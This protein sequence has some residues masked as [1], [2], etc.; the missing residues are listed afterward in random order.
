M[1]FSTTVYV[2]SGLKAHAHVTIQFSILE[3]FAFSATRNDNKLICCVSMGR[4]RTYWVK[5]PRYSVFNRPQS[6]SFNSAI[7]EER[8]SVISMHA[9]TKNVHISPT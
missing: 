2:R 3:I 7:T 8:R 4:S 5:P 6:T 1:Y 9:N